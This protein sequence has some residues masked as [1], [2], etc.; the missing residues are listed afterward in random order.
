MI[1]WIAI[2]LFTIRET[3]GRSWRGISRPAPAVQ[4]VRV[5]VAGPDFFSRALS[6]VSSSSAS[7]GFRE[8]R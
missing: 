2:L 4:P 7:K 5:R 1:R 8:F 6:D 3:L